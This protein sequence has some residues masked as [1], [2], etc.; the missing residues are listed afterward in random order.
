M[1]CTPTFLNELSVFYKFKCVTPDYASLPE[2]D[3][4]VWGSAVSSHRD[5]G[6]FG[7]AVRGDAFKLYNREERTLDGVPFRLPIPQGRSPGGIID[8]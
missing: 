8:F 5:D 3:R 2:G 6:I 4:R 7:L 1:L